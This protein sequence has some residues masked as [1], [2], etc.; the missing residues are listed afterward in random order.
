ML[1]F[2]VAALM[3]ISNISHAMKLP[4]RSRVVAALITLVSVLFTQLAVAAYVCPSVQLA[5]ALAIQAQQAATDHHNS[6]ICDEDVSDRSPLCQ[7]HL[8]TGAQSV[9][10]P[11]LPEI[12]PFFA[13]TLLASI[14]DNDAFSDLIR[15][16]S[17]RI[18]MRSPAPPLSIQNCCLRI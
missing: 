10:R 16:T 3:R 4:R 18:L 5:H 9:D 15:A 14:A 2:F 8:Q 6:S 1:F 17:P 7:T 13:M 12:A 11:P